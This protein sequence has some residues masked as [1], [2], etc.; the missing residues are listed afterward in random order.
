M[1]KL[2]KLRRWKVGDVALAVDSNGMREHVTVIRVGVVYL[3]VVRT[4]LSIAPRVERRFRISTLR[5]VGADG[6][7]VRLGDPTS[8]DFLRAWMRLV[9]AL[10]A[11]LS[12]LG[13]VIVGGQAKRY[14]EGEMP[15]PTKDWDVFVPFASWRRAAM[16]LPLRSLGLNGNRGFR[17]RATNGL[18]DTIDVWPDELARFLEESTGSEHVSARKG[19]Q[20]ALVLKTGLIVRAERLATRRS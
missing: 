12:S 8:E 10:V 3:T 7:L 11:Q 4:A 5:E 2:Q 18:K 17:V 16:L 20:Y 13:A 9:P 15:D 1:T 19:P 14:A 6:H